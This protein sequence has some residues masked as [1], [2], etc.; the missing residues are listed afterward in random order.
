MRR[1]P[2][3]VNTVIDTPSFTMNKVIAIHPERQSVD[4]RP[5][6]GSE[7][8]RDVHVSSLVGTQG[9]LA[10]LQSVTNL[11][12]LADSTGSL[13]DFTEDGKNSLYALVGYL[14][15]DLAQPM[16]M[17]WRMPPTTQMLFS[18]AGLKI[19]RHAESGIYEL[20]DKAGNYELVLPDGS[21]LHWGPGAAAHR[22]LTGTDVQKSWLVPVG[23]AQTFT[24]HHSTGA[25]LTIAADGSIT[26]VPASGKTVKLGTTGAAT[27][28]A[29]VG[30]TVSVTGT[31]SGTDPQGGTVTVSG[32]IT[33]TIT[34]GST[35]VTSA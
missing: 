23:A 32:T 21:Y 30:D 5:A 34:A 35:T 10:Y 11:S 27:G 2:G 4:L 1:G 16:V 9:G 25:Q 31:M 12:P 19:D 28:I 17:G 33:G 26:V 7:P 24:L 13:D 8:L 15:D 14:E 20:W 6:R 29:R 22:V 3:R 18:E